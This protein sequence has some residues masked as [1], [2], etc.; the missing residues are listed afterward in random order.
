MT[1]HDF[2]RSFATFTTPGRTNNARIQVEA[3]CDVTEGGELTRYVLVASCKA[4][5][6]YAEDNLLRAPGYDFCVVF[7]QAQYQI[8]RVRL[9]ITDDWLDPGLNAD[10]FDAV[11][12]GLVDR[13]AR[14]CSDPRE[15]VEATLANVPLVGVTELPREDGETYARLEYPI[16]TMN[17]NDQRWEFQVDT[18]PAIVPDMRRRV[19]LQVE[20]MD[21]AFVAWN[22]PKRAEFLIQEPTPVGGSQA[23]HYS[24]VVKTAARNRVLR[25]IEH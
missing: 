1:M 12:I 14:E 13:P 18:G 10:R 9:P 22:S 16:K 19:N 21:L 20:R 6:T 4:E 24:R 7:S 2:S 8:V 11:S 5:D 3:I 23:G 25:P 17:A 15:V